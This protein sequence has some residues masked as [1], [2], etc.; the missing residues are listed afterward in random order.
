M[1]QDRIRTCF[2]QEGLMLEGTP[3]PAMIGSFRVRLKRPLTV[4]GTVVAEQGYVLDAYTSP[5]YVYQRSAW[6]V[7][8]ADKVIEVFEEDV[9][10]MTGTRV[11]LATVPEKILSYIRP[12]HRG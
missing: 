6:V 7:L 4:L 11:E 12:D 1:D 9:E 10:L 3:I 5:G 2:L 8:V